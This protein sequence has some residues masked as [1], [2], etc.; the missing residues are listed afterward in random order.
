MEIQSLDL[1]MN[2]RLK[3]FIDEFLDYALE[4]L[5]NNKSFGN[6]QYD[7]VLDKIDNNWL[8]YVYDVVLDHYGMPYRNMVGSYYVFNVNQYINIR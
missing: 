1:F 7:Y 2:I 4:D 5:Q 3:T 8:L 6:M